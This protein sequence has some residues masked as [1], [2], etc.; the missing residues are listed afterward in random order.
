MT[1]ECLRKVLSYFAVGTE[2]LDLLFALGGKARDSEAGL[3]EATVVN[4]PDG[5]YGIAYIFPNTQLKEI[6]ASPAN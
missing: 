4:R 3:G 1:E 2:F 6:D 5:S